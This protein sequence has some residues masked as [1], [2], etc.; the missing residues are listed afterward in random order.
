MKK[1]L[2]I[3]LGVVVLLLVAAGIGVFVYIDVIAKRGIER[4]ATYA[5]GV[6]TTLDSA[7]VG[8]TSGE[9]TMDELAMDNPQGYTAEHF[10]KME[11]GYVHVGLGSLMEQ[12]IEVPAIELTGLN[13]QVE[14]AGGKNNYDVIL[15]NLKKLSSGEKPDKP[16]PDAK[17]Y[18]VRKLTINNTAVTIT[19]FGVG[20]QTV[21]LPTIELTDV[22]SGGDAKSMAEIVGIVIREIMQSLLSD[23][24]KL[25]GMLVGSLTEGLAGLGNL[26]DVGVETIGQIGEGV[27]QAVGEI[28]EKMGEISPEAGKAVEDV[29]GKVD[30]GVKD[31]Q[32]EIKEGLGGL[33]GGKKKQQDQEGEQPSE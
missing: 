22:G 1:K 11:K 10:L 15:D 26:G 7:D 19:G 32:D 20:S 29:K 12:Q 13:L 30:E 27:G 24:S 14:R 18:I 21:T 6:D 16:D 3:A 33:L 28:G 8:I 9:L 31:V 25:P 23:P 2:L 5:A 17:T 4:G